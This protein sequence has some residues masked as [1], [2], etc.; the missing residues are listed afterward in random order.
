[1]LC[2]D[3]HKTTPSVIFPPRL[4]QSKLCLSRDLLFLFFFV[5]NF[6]STTRQPF[7][8]AKCGDIKTATHTQVLGAKHMRDFIKCVA[9]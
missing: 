6:F 5:Y 2:N 8:P 3:T 9:L 4:S 7:N 1:M